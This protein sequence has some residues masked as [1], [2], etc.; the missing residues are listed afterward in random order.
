MPQNRHDGRN[1]NF[2]KGQVIRS[3]FR[4]GVRGNGRAAHEMSTEDLLKTVER[5][6]KYGQKARNVLVRRG[7]SL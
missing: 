3:K 6:G 7:V 1:K 5:G 2:R 4:I